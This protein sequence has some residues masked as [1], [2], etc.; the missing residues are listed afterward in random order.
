LTQPLVV[1]RIPSKE[2]SR[3]PDE[4]VRFGVKHWIKVEVVALLHEGDFSV[5]EIALLIGEDL[6]RVRNHVQELYEAGNI[7]VAGFKQV[8]NHKVAVYRAVAL[9][10]ISDEEAKTMTVEERHDVSGCITQGILAETVSAHRNGKLDEDP[11]CLLW[12][13]QA[14]DHQGEL[15]RHQLLLD[16]W[17]KAKKISVQTAHRLAKSGEIGRTN[18]IGLLGFERGRPGRPKDGYMR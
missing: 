4:A 17:E 10:E 14:L 18:V 5:G 3:G 11:V 8:G 7:E 9:A 6:K 13:A 2:R 15:E 16:T 12:G 1:G